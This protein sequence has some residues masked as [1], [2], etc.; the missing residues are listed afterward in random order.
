MKEAIREKQNLWRKKGPLS[1]FRFLT[2]PLQSDGM[3]MDEHLVG[4]VV[5]FGG[6]IIYAWIQTYLSYKIKSV[7]TSSGCLCLYRLTLSI[8]STVI[9]IV[10]LITRYVAN[11]QWYRDPPPHSMR[12]WQPGD[13]GYIP[14]V[15][16]SSTEWLTFALLMLYFASFYGEFHQIILILKVKKR[17]L[18]AFPLAFESGGDENKKYFLV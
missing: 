2:F 5:A 13:K 11:K 17:D 12:Y 7:E 1:L 16:G 3:S 8:L 4:A 15:I 9:V 10:C 6:G 14:H 18:L